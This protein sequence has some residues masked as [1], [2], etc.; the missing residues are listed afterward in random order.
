M[1]QRQKEV[2]TGRKERELDGERQGWKKRV[3]D[4]GAEI[5]QDAPEVRTPLSFW[6]GQGAESDVSRVRTHAKPPTFVSDLQEIQ[7]RV[8]LLPRSGLRS[9]NGRG[10]FAGHR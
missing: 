8:G 10:R 1:R 9:P 5:M 2:E 7:D 3:G 6:V 4:F